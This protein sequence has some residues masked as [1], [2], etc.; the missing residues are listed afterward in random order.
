M[1]EPKYILTTEAGRYE[2]DNLFF[3]IWEVVI[4]RTWHLIKDG[5]WVD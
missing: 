4:H 5:R 1:A 3:L 2:S